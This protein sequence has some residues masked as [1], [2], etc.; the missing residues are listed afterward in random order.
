NTPVEALEVAYPLRVEEYRL[1]AGSGGDGARRG[2]E[3]V[4]RAVRALAPLEASII[5]ERRRRGPRGHAGGGDGAAGRNLLNGA[6]LPAKWRGQLRPD[7]VLTIETP[8]GGGH[9]RP[10]PG[11][12]A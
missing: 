10:L 3:G 12:G 11:E 8:G 1:R 9:G 7:D 2:G 4:V 6:E 5:A